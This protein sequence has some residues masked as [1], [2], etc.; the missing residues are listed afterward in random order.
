MRFLHIIVILLAVMVETAFSAPKQQSQLIRAKR[1]WG[2]PPYGGG[3]RPPYGG[4]FWPPYG[5]GFR[6]PYGGGFRPPYGGGFRPPYGG[7]FRPPIDIGQVPMPI[8]G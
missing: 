4:G 1:Q 6:P 7:G 2:R 3:F 8:S 5:G